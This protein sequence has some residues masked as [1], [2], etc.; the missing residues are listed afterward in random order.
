MSQDLISNDMT[1]LYMRRDYVVEES[2]VVDNIYKIND[3]Y[4]EELAKQN[5]DRDKLLKLFNQQLMEGLK[6]QMFS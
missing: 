5:P 6:L 2:R 1:D 4:K 3:K